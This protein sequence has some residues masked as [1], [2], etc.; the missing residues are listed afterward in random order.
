MFMHDVGSIL[1]Q[2]DYNLEHNDSLLVIDLHHDDATYSSLVSHTTKYCVFR[3]PQ[4]T[5]IFRRQ[6]YQL[7]KLDS[8]GQP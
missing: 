2:N 8:R 6:W 3:A 1:K 5:R 7:E 4:H